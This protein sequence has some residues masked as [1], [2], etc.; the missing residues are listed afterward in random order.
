MYIKEINTAPL[1]PIRKAAEIV[2]ISIPT[3]RMYERE[4]LILPKKSA[5]NQRRYSEADIERLRCIRHTINAEK[6]SI[7]GIKRILSLIPCWQILACSVADRDQCPA[8][9]NY[10]RPCWSYTHK[11]TTC[12]N[13]DCSSCGVYNNFTDCHGIKNLIKNISSGQ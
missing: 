10:I 4:G 3:I 9:H 12:A 11:R 1:F 7:Q 13:R 8:Y 2:G 6:I 5:G